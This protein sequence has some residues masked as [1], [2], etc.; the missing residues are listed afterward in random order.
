MVKISSTNKKVIYSFFFLLFYNYISYAQEENENIFREDVI[1]DTSVTLFD[2]ISSLDPRRAALLSAILPGLG[3]IYNKQYWKVPLV[4]SGF[5]AF[6]Q[7][8][9]YN[10]SI[11]HA[12]RNA[13]IAERDNNVLSKN[14]FEQ[15]I[16]TTDNLIRNRDKF[17]RDR[18]YTIILG[19]FFYFIQ[20]IDAHVFAHL[21][22]FNINEKLSINIRPSFEPFFP[23]S[24]AIGVSL[25]LGL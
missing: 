10:N 2:E 15:I 6:A 22:E 3:Q 9:S 24:R 11:Y 13:L 23:S 17:R 21:D 7:V 1:S 16:N 18:D 25:V 12:L 8:I 20:I 14:P 5:F 19:T 4:V